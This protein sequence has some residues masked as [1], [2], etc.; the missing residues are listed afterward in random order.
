MEDLLRSL[1]A[2]VTG[3]V[4][5][6]TDYL[7]AGEKAGSKLTRAQELNI[8]ILNEEEFRRFLAERGVNID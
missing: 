2:N 7:I 8:T 3:S 1:G 6:N 4:N 5:K